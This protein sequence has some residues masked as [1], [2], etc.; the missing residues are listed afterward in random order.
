MRHLAAVISLFA[1]SLVSIFFFRNH[2]FSID[3]TTFNAILIFFWLGVFVFTIIIRSGL[4]KKYPDPSLTV[5]QMLWGTCFVLAITYLLNEWRGL[6]LMA[7]FGILS[8]GYFKLKFSEFLSVAL[9]AVLGYAFIIMYIYAYE[10][11]RIIIN[12]E[13]AQLLAF[14]CTISVMLYTGSAIHSL[15]ERTK[16]QYIALQEALEINQKLATTDDLT[17]LYNRRF[18]MEQLSQQ[19][20]LSE[21]DDSDFIL[22]F[23]DL[24]HFKQINDTFGHYTGDIVL[25]NFSR[26]VKS[27]IREIDYAARFGG[28]EFVCLLVNT[29]IENA[30]KVA[31]RIRLS[32][33]SYNFSDIAPSLHS[34]V[35]IG[36]ANFKQ[37]KTIQETLMSADNRMYL[38]KEAGRNKVVSAD[39]DEDD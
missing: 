20:A 38:A 21:R 12:L 1:F 36:V 26:I 3:E 28:E 16:K 23:C 32:L 15:R 35:S 11:E 29:D 8:F 18:F 25:K 37:F 24:D 2:L 4:N 31:E 5:P 22:C 19:K 13:L 27:S 17:G 39:E 14:T 10:S 6:M 33:A 9:F 30:I 7:Y 34:T